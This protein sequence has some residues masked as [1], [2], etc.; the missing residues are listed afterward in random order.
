MGHQ[1]WQVKAA[2]TSNAVAINSE[3]PSNIPG[4]EIMRKLLLLLQIA[5]GQEPR[6]REAS[7]QG[8]GTSSPTFQPL[9]RGEEMEMELLTKGYI[10]PMQ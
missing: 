5:S 2:I 10:V 6:V 1:G 9:G 3:L 4:S 7:Q 8:C